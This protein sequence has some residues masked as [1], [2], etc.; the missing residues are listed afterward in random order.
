MRLVPG[1]LAKEGALPIPHS[2]NMQYCCCRSVDAARPA[3][4]RTAGEQSSS[5]QSEGSDAA[6]DFAEELPAAITQPSGSVSPT[7]LER[8]SS[9]TRGESA[10]GVRHSR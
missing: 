5:R 10:D 6:A 3:V 8:F 9:L 7:R 1:L 2:V 4:D